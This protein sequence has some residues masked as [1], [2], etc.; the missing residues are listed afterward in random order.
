MLTSTVQLITYYAERTQDGGRHPEK[1]VNK[2]NDYYPTIRIFCDFINNIQ[3]TLMG[4]C[5]QL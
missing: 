5:H 1:S 4:P 3:E 2:K